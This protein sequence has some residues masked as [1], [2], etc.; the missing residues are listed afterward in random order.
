MFK[1]IG[2]ELVSINS[3]KVYCKSFH[4]RCVI[5]LLYRINSSKVYCKC[6]RYKLVIY[7]IFCI[8]SSKV[9]CKYTKKVLV[10]VP[11]CR[12][13]SSKVYCKLETI[14]NNKHYNIVLIVAKCIVNVFKVVYTIFC[15][16][17]Y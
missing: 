12:I 2:N 5:T 11:K 4:V 15:M 1:Y 9:Y 3:S 7:S 8:N 17:T 14:K 16:S 6:R 13:N 10:P